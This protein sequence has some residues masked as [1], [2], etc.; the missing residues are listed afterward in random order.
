[1]SEKGESSFKAAGV[2]I[3]CLH[4]G[5]EVFEARE[6]LMNTRGASLINLD[7]LNRGATAL[8]CSKCGRVE[9]FATRPEPAD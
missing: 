9:W 5:C 7:W 2:R 4:C 8:T 1:M 6:V 3:R